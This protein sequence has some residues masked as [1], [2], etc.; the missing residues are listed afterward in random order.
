[1]RENRVPQFRVGQ[2]CQ[3]RRLHGGHDLAGFGPDHGEAKNAV[4]LR[5]DERLH[6]PLRFID[7]ACAQHGARRQFGHPHGEVSTFRLTL[8]QPHPGEWWVGEHAVGNEPV[9]CRALPSGQ[10]VANDPEVIEGDMRELRAAS[11]FADCPDVGP[12]RLQPLV[13]PN[14]APFVQCNSC[15]IQTDPASVGPAPGCDQDVAALNR[16]LTR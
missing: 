5:T 1:M 13:D 16:T 9:A 2:L 15:E 3:H 12:A 14:I 4:V 6:E 10:V 8:V 7:R 11:A